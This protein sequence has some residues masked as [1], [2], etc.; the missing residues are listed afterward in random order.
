MENSRSGDGD[1]NG[2]ASKEE[3]EEGGGALGEG[4]ADAAGTTSLSSPPRPHGSDVGF[5]VRA[6]PAEASVMATLKVRGRMA[7]KVDESRTG[8]GANECLTFFSQ[9]DPSKITVC[10]CPIF[11]PSQ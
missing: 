2:G 5:G 11:P 8:E 3:E 4:G 9:P 6:R 1:D 7:G 10:I